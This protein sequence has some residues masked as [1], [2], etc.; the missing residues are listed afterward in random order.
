MTEANIFSNARIGFARLLSGADEKPHDLFEIEK[1]EGGRLYGDY[2]LAFLKD[3]AHFNVEIAAFG[4][5]DRRNAGDLN[6]A[7]RQHFSV[8]ECLAAEQLIRSFFPTLAFSIRVSF[9]GKLF[10]ARR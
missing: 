4:Y 5:L 10:W 6:P 3:D 8:E 1:A 7:R 2:V 9:P